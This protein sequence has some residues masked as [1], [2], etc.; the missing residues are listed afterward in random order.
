MLNFL[1]LVISPPEN[2]VL[3]SGSYDPVLVSLSILVA[4]FASYAALLV[5]QH[6]SVATIAK[7]RRM[8]IA[9][10]G[11]CL[12]VGIWAMH[13]IGMLAFSLPYSSSYDPVLTLLSAIPGIFASTLAINIISRREFPR[14]RL[15]AGGLLIGVGIVAMHYSGM[16][17]MRLDGLIRYD[18]K[19]FLISILAA[20]VFAVLALWI[21]FRLQSWQP[22]WSMWG[23]IASAVVMGLA[24]SGMH[25]MAMAAAYFIRDGGHTIVDPGMEPT[26]LAIIVM[27][28]TSLII[29]TT[30]VATYVGKPNLLSLGQS[31]RLIGVLIVGWSAIA[32]LSA[33]YYY[34]HLASN[35]YQQ[36]SQ[37]AKRQAE[38]I[39]RNIDKDIELLKGISI[40][41]SRDDEVLL[42][43][44]R[45]GADVAPST[46]AP[47][48][49]RQR[50]TRDRILSEA[51]DSLSIAANNL[52]ADIIFIINAAGDCV[53][54]SNAGEPGSAVGANY[55]DRA[56]FSQVQAGRAG[57]Q[58]A[59]G[60]T[61]NIPGLYYAYPVFA[62]ERFLGAVV[63]KRDI[64]SFSYWTNQANAFLA[65][66]NGVIV[67]APDKGLELHSLANATVANLSAEKKVAQYKRSVIKP[68]EIIPWGDERFPSAAF[69][70][71]EK[72]PVVLASK[73]MPEDAI[74]IYVPRPLDELVRLGAER[75][76]LF[77]LLAIAGSMLMVATSAI[78]IYLRE[79][80]R[81]A[82]DLRIAATAFKL[83]ESL[84]ITDA[85]GVILRVN[86]AFT[87]NTG[88]TA[89]EAVGQTPRI[90][91]SGRHDVDFYRAMW[92][93]I[94]RTGTWQGEIW[95]RRKN[96]EIHPQWL[97]ISAVK[98][99]DGTVTH[100]VGSHIDITERKAA[101]EEIKYLA[102]YDPLTHLPN[103][104]LLMDRLQRALAFS[105]RNNQEGALLLIDLDNFK[106][107]NDTRGH[108]IGDQLLQQVGQRLESCIRESDT[109]AR[110]GGDEFVVM[111]EGLCEQILDASAQTASI[112]EKILAA[113]SQ[114]YQ[115][116]SYEYHS[117]VSIGATLFHG[118]QQSIDE[119]LKQADIAMYQAKKSGRN[120]LRFFDPQM[121]TNITTR[122]SLEGE[123]R[124]AL[125]RRQLH[126]YYQIQ[127]NS[128]N[129]PLGAEA[130]I[131]WIH[132]E[133]GMVSPAQFIPLAEE[134]GLILPIGQWVLETAC[135]QIKA[136]QQDA[137]TSDLLLA[138][139]VSAKQFRQANFVAQVQAAVQHHA[140]N[141]MLLKLELTEGM[142]LENIENVIATMTALKAIGV[143]I[144]LDDFGTGYSSLQYLKRLPLDQLKIDQSFVRD[145]ATDNSDK[146]IVRTIIAMAHSLSLDVIAEGVETEE[147]R[148]ILLTT[149]CTH[150]Q[151]YLFGRPMPIE[152]F[153]EMLKQF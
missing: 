119:L 106:E 152:Q 33:S 17:A 32:W 139:N 127:M 138:V 115:L 53:A 20:I 107:L 91:K 10:G 133:R 60:R 97:N 151:G 104:R 99:D 68:L 26:L 8:W 132:P 28:A 6:V 130:L 1:H 85:G 93:S 38:G 52:G 29:V 15:A 145:I 5:S 126:L 103:R 79:S 149:A 42:S 147:Q 47:E 81:T 113:L 86:Q 70:G 95:D 34:G 94:Q 13:F 72:F 100:Y 24:V 69:I 21:K 11:L 125:E 120:V 90:L 7:I 41:V 77:I 128:S 135:A 102:F 121:Q 136:W 112:G 25:Y 50:W 2:S 49:R 129:R 117:T 137:R 30:I 14:A 65:D 141:P 122:V 92:E 144:S 109:V 66:A 108:D 75:Y 39:A 36:E 54:A 56:Y 116:A 12:G 111:L 59:V 37:L 96:G 43:L 73:N 63:V 148:H 140:I 124:K 74:T 51:N 62:K 44:Q 31:H 101:E 78:V 143:R 150:F 82:D 84:M 114:P 110:L 71:G 146:A 16:A 134:T 98:G 4:I 131:R 67:L 76:W 105:A 64:T 19:L 142:L 23:V 153:G 123:L 57:H 22:R 3:Y 80:C 118:Q 87:E 58:Y 88:Y 9:V 61:T 83:H 27:V 89:E 35:L 55:S 18:I 45:F 40:M 48:E 46:L